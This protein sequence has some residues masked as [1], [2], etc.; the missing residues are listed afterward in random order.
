MAVELTTLPLEPSL[1]GDARPCSLT[2]VLGTRLISTRLAERTIAFEGD[3]P[4]DKSDKRC[5]S[6][7]VRGRTSVSPLTC[8]VENSRYSRT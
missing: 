6:T 5:E 1:P 7:G 4:L 3:S 2:R 8:S